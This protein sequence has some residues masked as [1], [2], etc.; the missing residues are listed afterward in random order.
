MGKEL[1]FRAYQQLVANY[2]QTRSGEKVIQKEMVPKVDRKQKE[3]I[4][5]N[6][7]LYVIAIL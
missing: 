1:L 7:A 6:I 5:A 4:S 3:I 2:W